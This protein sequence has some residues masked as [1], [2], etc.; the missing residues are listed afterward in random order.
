MDTPATEPSAASKPPRRWWYFPFRIARLVAMVYLGLMLCA[1]FFEEKLIFFPSPYPEGNWK[2]HALEFEDVEFAAADGVHLHGWYCPVAN[3]RAVVLMSHGNA[4]NITH[5]TDEILLWQ[6]HL[7]VSVFIYDYRG[8]GRSEGSPNEAGVYADARGAYR[9]LTEDKGIDAGEVVFRGESIGSAVSLQLALD[10][11][12]RALIMES[13]FTS[14]VD[15]GRLHYG[16]L[17]VRLV[18]RNRFESIDKIGK[19]RGPLLITHGTRD[20]IIPFTMGQALFDR[21]NEPKTFYAVKGADHNDVPFA[22]GTAYFQAIDRF[23]KST[24]SQ[25][26]PQESSSH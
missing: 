5:R 13:P 10:V 12:H 1:M 19:Y 23:L 3:P 2:P 25:S 20:S 7:R 15:V 4:G 8:F 6:R 26:D 11:P 17:P 24:V 16:W 21:A 14:A 9:W 18:M 22:G